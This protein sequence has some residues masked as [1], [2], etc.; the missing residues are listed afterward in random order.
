MKNILLLLTFSLS[1]ISFAEVLNQKSGPEGADFNVSYGYVENYTKK[2]FA[3]RLGL[4]KKKLYHGC[5][6]KESD[7]KDKYNK[8]LSLITLIDDLTPK[9]NPKKMIL[10]NAKKD[11]N[12]LYRDLI[13]LTT[14]GEEFDM[15]YYYQKLALK[16]YNKG[17]FNDFAYEFFNCNARLE[18]NWRDLSET[19]ATN[20]F[21]V[22]VPSLLAAGVGGGMLYSDGPNEGFSVLAGAGVV[23]LATSVGMLAKSNAG[24]NRASYLVNLHKN[25]RNSFTSPYINAKEK[26]FIR[27]MHEELGLSYQELAERV[28]LAIDSGDACRV[29]KNKIISKGEFKKLISLY[30]LPNSSTHA[31]VS[32]S[33]KIKET[34]SIGGSSNK[35]KANNSS[36]SK[37]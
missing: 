12:N 18:D 33:S 25:A 9:K 8:C 13:F 27:Q 14:N 21:K 34:N 36:A 28:K 10:E 20:A 19:Q 32:D 7:E 26:K 5:M 11:E 2:N 31:E 17:W 24:S 30:D 16:R 35:L 15:S 3:E 4:A 22:L 23:G 6:V 1:Q 29:G 37:M